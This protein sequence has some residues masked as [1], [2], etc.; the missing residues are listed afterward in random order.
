[1]NSPTDVATSSSSYDLPTSTTDNRT[2]T[3]DLATTQKTREFYFQCAV[4]VIGIV[5]MIANAFVLFVL[6]TSR[7]MKKHAVNYLLFNQ[8]ALDLCS[9]I[10][11][12]VTYSVKLLEINL[13]GPGGYWLCILLLS[14]M[15]FFACIDAST[16]NFAFIAVERYLK[17]VHVIWH[18]NNFQPRMAFA[19]MVV[20]WVAGG[21]CNIALVPPTTQVVDGQCLAIVFWTNRVT[22]RAFGIWYFITFFLL[23]IVTCSYCYGRIMHAVLIRRRAK[24]AAVAIPS[25]SRTAPTIMQPESTVNSSR[26]QMNTVKTMVIL[27]MFY[28]VSWLPNQIYYL[29]LNFYDNLTPLDSGWYCTLFIGFF[30]ICANPIVYASKSS[31]VKEYL[32][33]FCRVRQSNVDVDRNDVRVTRHQQRL[34]VMRLRQGLTPAAI[35]HQGVS[36]ERF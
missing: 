6:A 11:L 34:R 15:F 35:N 23:T 32:T 12:V 3:T 16:I 27:V 4:L 29:L 17:I 26:Q 2:G 31:V 19:A 36:T 20:A 25:T 22:K 9:S 5:G 21:T 14:E 7:Q 33:K 18:K 30:N 10:L 8:L 13:T 28:A 24:V 1:M